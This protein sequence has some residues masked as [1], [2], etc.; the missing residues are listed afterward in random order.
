MRHI[1]PN[2]WRNSHDQNLLDCNSG[3]QVLEISRV[4]ELRLFKSKLPAGPEEDVKVVL[5]WAENKTRLRFVHLL[6]QGIISQ[7]FSGR[8]TAYNPVLLKFISLERRHGWGGAC[9]QQISSDPEQNTRKHTS[10]WERLLRDTGWLTATK[11][12]VGWVWGGDQ[13]K[14]RKH[15]V[16]IIHRSQTRWANANTNMTHAETELLSHPETANSHACQA[17]PMWIPVI[18]V[19]KRTI[20]ETIGCYK[21]Q[22]QATKSVILEP[23]DASGRNTVSVFFWL[24]K[25]CR[26]F[27]CKFDCDYCCEKQTNKNNVWI[28]EL[29]VR[30]GQDGFI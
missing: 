15:D 10:W 30:T 18:P 13:A 9:V 25:P 12:P 8:D 11:L 1:D 16:R 26:W 3:G 23:L 24:C 4:K 17:L 2:I 19:G 27:S 5:A 29:E 20:S 6:R 7:E 14:T 22:G 21:T 28:F